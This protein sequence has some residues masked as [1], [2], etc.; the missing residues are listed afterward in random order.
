[1]ADRAD[2]VSCLAGIAIPDHRIGIAVSG[3]G[4]SLAALVAA[5][6]AGLNV[7]AATVDHGLRPESRR[8]AETV[9][10]FCGERGIPHRILS[11][12]W[13]G[14]GNLSANAREGRLQALAEWASAEDLACVVLGHTRDDVA[15]TF[16]MRLARKS[17][18]DGLST[19]R[20]SFTVDNVRFVRPLLCVSRASLRAFLTARGHDWI[21]DPTNCD[22]TYERARIRAGLTALQGLGIDADTLAAVADQMRGARTALDATAL[23]LVDRHCRQTAGAL[24]ISHRLHDEPEELV[25]RVYVASLRWVGAQAYAPRRDD[26]ARFIAAAKAG[27][28]ATL[29]GVRLIS[30][31]SEALMVREYDAVRGRSGRVNDPWDQ[32][33]RLAGPSLDG[34][35][36]RDLGPDGL[37]QCPDWRKTGLRR[38]ILLPTPAIWQGDF[39]VAAPLA[40]LS[41]GWTAMTASFRDE[42]APMDSID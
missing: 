32:R 4:D 35:E 31:S 33:W 23:N 12:N 3:G 14:T 10:Q 21:E 28:D 20:A 16:V 1:V 11:W 36:V 41:D 38:E 13:D 8:E 30:Q 42:F 40:G 37:S 6:E 5:C 9:A 29:H 2:P 25:R 24:V 22:P 26:A 27:R 18:V 39:L 17:G 34:A 19:M 15:E 7:R